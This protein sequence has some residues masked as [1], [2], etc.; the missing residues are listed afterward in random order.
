MKVEDVIDGNLEDPTLVD[1]EQAAQ[2]LQELKEK[3][4]AKVPHIDKGVR[5]EVQ[6]GKRKKTKA[7]KTRKEVQEEEP[8]KR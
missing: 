7:R 8:R 2:V 4:K 6:E 5:K 1:F 3:R